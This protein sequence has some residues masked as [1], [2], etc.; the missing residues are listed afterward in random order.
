MA[1]IKNVLPLLNLQEHYNATF[2][3]SFYKSSSRTKERN[4]SIGRALEYKVSKHR[5]CT[6]ALKMVLKHKVL[7]YN[8]IAELQEGYRSIGRI[9]KYGKG[10]KYKSSAK[11][12]N[13]H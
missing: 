12:Q 6:K 3:Y 13:R 11:T 5:K 7:K 2:I 9:L 1:F 8:N 10:L 4:Q